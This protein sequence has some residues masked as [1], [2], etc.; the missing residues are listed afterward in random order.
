MLVRHGSQAL[1]A[2]DAWVRVRRKHLAE[3]RRLPEAKH[4]MIVAWMAGLLAVAVAIELVI[5]LLL[6]RFRYMAL[7]GRFFQEP[8][9]L[10]ARRQRP[11]EDRTDCSFRTSDGLTLQGSYLA[12]AA[13][14]RRGVIVFCHELTGDRWGALPYVLRLRSQ[15]FDIFVFDFRNH[16]ASDCEPGYQPLPWPT[17]RELIDIEAAIDCVQARPDADPRGVILYGV[18]RG[19]SAAL[20]TAAEHRAVRAVITDGA[21]PFIPTIV[22]WIRRYMRIFTRWSYALHFVPDWAVAFHL[23]WALKVI[24]RTHAWRFVRPEHAAPAVRV[25]VLMIHGAADHF[26]PVDVGLALAKRLP[27]LQQFWTAPGA[28]HNR[29]VEVAATDYEA[30]LDNFLDA[31]PPAEPVPVAQVAIDPLLVRG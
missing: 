13:P 27:T 30:L 17:E 15:G 29:A 18:S 20:C 25:P 26:I 31:A 5:W 1:T 28:K 2:N 8:A 23:L 9:M 12:A 3:D 22:Q 21:Y 24:E 16:G 11:V 19:A 10:C 7:M 14:R 4:V 6:F